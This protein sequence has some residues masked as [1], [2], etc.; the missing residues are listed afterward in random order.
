MDE[1]DL[2]IIGEIENDVLISKIYEEEKNNKILFEENRLNMKSDSLITTFK[3]LD[4]NNKRNAYN[5]EIQ[6][7]FELLKHLNLID[8]D[9]C[10]YNYNSN[11]DSILSE[12]EYLTFE[13]KNILSIRQKLISYIVEKE[14]K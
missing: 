11:T 10:I 4:Y 3:S 7:I 13:Y 5:T 6:K 12:G 9:D 2:S 1:K 8:K 14:N